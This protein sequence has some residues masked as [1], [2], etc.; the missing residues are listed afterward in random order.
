MKKSN[1]KEQPGYT[2]KNRSV[3]ETES[4]AAPKKESLKEP[5]AIIADRRIELDKLANAVEKANAKAVAAMFEGVSETERSR[6]RAALLEI[7]GMFGWNKAKIKPSAKKNYSIAECKKKCGNYFDCFV[8]VA[9]G[10]PRDQLDYAISRAL[11]VWP[12]ETCKVLRDRSA[13]WLMPFLKEKVKFDTYDQWMLLVSEGVYLPKLDEAGVQA[14]ILSF[15]QDATAA[16]IK[17][18][19]RK[20]PWVADLVYQVYSFEN[21]LVDANHS[22]SWQPGLLEFIDYLTDQKVLDR[23]KLIDA[24]LHGM[25]QV[26]KAKHVGACLQILEYVEP[27][28]AEWTANQGELCAAIASCAPSGQV[29]LLEQLE[30][31]CSSN[32]FDGTSASLAIAAFLPDANIAAARQACLALV[33]MG[34]NL[35]DRRTVASCLAQ[36]L[37]HKKRE[38]AELGLKSLSSLYSSQ[39]EVAVHVVNSVLPGCSRVIKKQIQEWLSGKS[40]PQNLEEIKKADELKSVGVSK[41]E[42][43]IPKKR[44]QLSEPLKRSRETIKTFR[45]ELPGFV[46]SVGLER[47]LLVN[48]Y[49]RKKPKLWAPTT[50][51]LFDQLISLHFGLPKT[52]IAQDILALMKERNEF[53]SNDYWWSDWS[54]SFS[55]AVALEDREYAQKLANWINFQRGEASYSIDRIT[56]GIYYLTVL[57]TNPFRRDKLVLTK[58]RQMVLEKDKYAKCWL[59]AYRAFD[60][61]REEDFINRFE[62]AVQ[63]HV[64]QYRRFRHMPDVSELGTVLWG[65]AK[66]KGMDVNKIRPEVMAAIMTPNSLMDSGEPDPNDSLPL[67]VPDNRLSIHLEKVAE[68]FTACKIPYAITVPCTEESREEIKVIRRQLVM[69]LSE[70][71][72]QKLNQTHDPFQFFL[73]RVALESVRDY[74]VPMLFDIK[75]ACGLNHVQLPKV[76]IDNVLSKATPTKQN[77]IVVNTVC[78]EHIVAMMSPMV[79]YIDYRSWILAKKRAENFDWSV[80]K[81]LASQIPNAEEMLASIAPRRA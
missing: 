68:L 34:Q 5:A 2:Q 64:E 16:K 21:F 20:F 80:A 13:E 14:L 63:Q 70:E 1:N 3:A 38:I 75:N 58:A 54:K 52:L 59:D 23:G 35:A 6:V 56:P 30:R 26:P 27:S 39:D 8:P 15:Y 45:A 53:K 40:I 72:F 47:H 22:A 62:I 24:V 43:T 33:A 77:G 50:T 46:A 32:G 66:R 10:G 55:A 36:A 12:K 42:N 69:E 49:R 31:C 37:V 51:D 9:V 4:A 76:A 44:A 57:L 65:V 74:L 61:S 29:Y 11:C 79:E 81:Q 48:H 19:Y 73:S 78:K 67:P 18:V 17:K 7:H 41:G 60:E 25:R 71:T 28:A